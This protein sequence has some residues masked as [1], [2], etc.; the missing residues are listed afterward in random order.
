M[1]IPP[2][3]TAFHR[4]I[5]FFFQNS[6]FL[7]TLTALCPGP[8]FTPASIFRRNDHLCT[9]LLNLNVTLFK[10]YIC[11]KKKKLLMQEN[12][13]EQEGLLKGEFCD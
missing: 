2:H 7:F 11:K 1:F 12:K 13:R 4:I 3:D 10:N 6:F 9:L 8:Y 5:T